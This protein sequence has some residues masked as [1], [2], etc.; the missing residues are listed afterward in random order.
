MICIALDRPEEAGTIIEGDYYRT[1]MEVYSNVTMRII[2]PATF[3][4]WKEYRRV[5]GIEHDF[6]RQWQGFYYWAH[7]D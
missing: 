5:N 6:P 2:R 3:E 7:T 4:E 1:P